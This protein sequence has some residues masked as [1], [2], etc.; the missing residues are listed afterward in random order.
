M[1]NSGT[2]FVMQP[3]D[4]G[5]FDKRYDDVLVPAIRA[6]G[7]EPYRVDRD[8][9]AAV[10]IREIEDGIKVARICLADISTDRMNVAFELGYA[11]A[12]DRPFVLIAKSGTPRW[13]DIQH[14]D[15][16]YY[17]VHST[18]D[19]DELKGKVTAALRA[20]VAKAAK[21]EKLAQVLMPTAGLE[22]HEVAALVSLA[23]LVNSTT[24]DASVYSVRQEMERLGYT[25]VATTLGL[26]ALENCGFVEADTNSSNPR[27]HS[28]I[29]AP[30]RRTTAAMRSRSR[31]CGTRSTTPS[32]GSTTTATLY[33]IRDLL[34]PV[35]G[36]RA[37]GL[38][39]R[40]S[41]SGPSTGRR[42]GSRARRP[43]AAS[44]RSRSARLLPPRAARRGRSSFGS[45]RRPCPPSAARSARGS[46]AQS[47]SARATRPCRRNRGPRR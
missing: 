41:P 11:M 42:S 33:A 19:F 7:L 18:R 43:C 40:H 27:S 1:S 17:D 4:K 28:T 35:D 5:E 3:F 26:A 32:S 21:T 16:I 45:A 34:R 46:R 6:S 39:G 14:N 12:L 29:Q 22:Q 10:P 25:D 44:R 38:D 13:F 20:R 2:C 24:D 8:P 37:L 23:S 47:R 15:I 9:A 31:P 36:D 30:L